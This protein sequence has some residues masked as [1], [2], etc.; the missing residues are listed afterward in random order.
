M[1]HLQALVNDGFT[2]VRSFG[3]VMAESAP[4]IYLSALPF[5]PTSSLIAAQYSQMFPHTLSV[6]GKASHWPALELIIQ[7]EKA[8]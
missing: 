8:V 1:V 5:A 6:K 4:H 2:F 3:M 7:V